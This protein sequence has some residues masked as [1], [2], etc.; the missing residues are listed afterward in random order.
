[1]DTQDD[2]DSMR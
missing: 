1:M 2:P